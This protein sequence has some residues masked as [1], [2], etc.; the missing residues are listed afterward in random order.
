M[1]RLLAKAE[2]RATPRELETS[3]WKEM[4]VLGALIV[5][6][7][8][9]VRCRRAME[10]DLGQR[11]IMENKIVLRMD[12]DY[13]ATI[14]T[15]FGK[16][17]FPLFAY[18]R[19]QNG[20]IVTTTPSRQDVFPYHRKCR[21]SELCLEWEIRLASDHPFLHFPCRRSLQRTLPCAPT[22]G[23]RRGSL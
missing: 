7:L 10:D 12:E 18:R 14:T 20:A 6:Y 11:D 9:A 16:I 8:F 3:L 13:W 2:G 21:S 1:S 5:A 19:E 17:Q 4:I 22:D 23:T 15:T